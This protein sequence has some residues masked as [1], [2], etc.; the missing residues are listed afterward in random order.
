MSTNAWA[1]F[2][3]L[4]TEPC[5]V[6]V[7]AGHVLEVVPAS[8]SPFD[9]DIHV[10]DLLGLRQAATVEQQSARVLVVNDGVEPKGLLV[11]F[12]IS[13]LR[14]TLAEIAPFPTLLRSTG[15]Y[16]GVL[17]QGHAATA[18]ILD[19][20]KL[21]IQPTNEARRSSSSPSAPPLDGR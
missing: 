21:S 9:D 11:P 6:A 18:L 15:A 7:P 3:V 12:A 1:E 2:L 16:S 4:E 17:I 19:P 10:V 8:E 20:T 13:L 5:R 14:V